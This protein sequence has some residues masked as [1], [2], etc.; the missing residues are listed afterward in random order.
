M[1]CETIHEAVVDPFE[2]SDSDAEMVEKPDLHP[3]LPTL[4]GTGHPQ[5]IR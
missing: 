2:D 3:E 5:W 4:G 1:P